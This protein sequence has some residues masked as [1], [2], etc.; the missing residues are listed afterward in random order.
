MTSEDQQFIEKATTK[1]FGNKAKGGVVANKSQEQRP[2]PQA[3]GAPKQS[4]R[5]R[6]F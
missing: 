5:L 3:K 4:I 6:T 1:N 2:K